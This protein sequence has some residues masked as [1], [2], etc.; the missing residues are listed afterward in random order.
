MASFTLTT[1]ADTFVGGPA[2]DTVNG[3]AATLNSTDSLSGDGGVD[4]L[5]L[6]GSGSFR[7]DQLTTFTGFERITLDN[8]TT[9]SATLTLG[10]QAIEVDS[11]GTVAIQI[12]S[13]SNWN[14]SNVI[15]GDA[16]GNRTAL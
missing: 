8:A 2:D 1:N 13:P 14:G 3:T 6:T 7:V 15:H 5:A 10:N 9:S 4:T 16:A 12:N 11:T